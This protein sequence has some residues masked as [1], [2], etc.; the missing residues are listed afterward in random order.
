[1]C[2]VGVVPL[3]KERWAIFSISALGRM[4]PV[5]KSRRK[6][7]NLKLQGGVFFFHF[8]PIDRLDGVCIVR[9]SIH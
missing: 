9:G 3:K 6:L 1:M 8:D 2:V 4:R 7:H 5:T